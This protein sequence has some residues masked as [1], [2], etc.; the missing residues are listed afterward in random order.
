MVSEHL[1]SG[2]LVQV[3]GDWC[4]RYPGLY[5]YYPSRRQ[6]PMTLKALIE[7]VRGTGA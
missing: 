5:L 7:L 6:V 2:R 3:L 4:P 1:A